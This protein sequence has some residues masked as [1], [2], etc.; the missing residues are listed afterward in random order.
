MAYHTAGCNPQPASAHV[1]HITSRWYCTPCF[2][3]WGIPLRVIWIPVLLGFSIILTAHFDDGKC[4]LDTATTSKLH[5]VGVSITQKSKLLPRKWPCKMD[6]VLSKKVP[7][8]KLYYRWRHLAGLSG[9]THICDSRFFQCMAT[10]QCLS[11]NPSF[12][13]IPGVVS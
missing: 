6:V 12:L 5:V 11:P 9:M 10:D 8:L 1:D 7:L 3:Q 4:A 2:L 13:V